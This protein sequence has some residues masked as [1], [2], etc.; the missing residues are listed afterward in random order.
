MGKCSL[1]V[2]AFQD[3]LP[4]LIICSEFRLTFGK[5]NNLLH[6]P[7]SILNML[8]GAECLALGFWRLFWDWWS[9]DHNSFKE[10]LR[11]KCFDD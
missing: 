1:R 6:I 9:F 5:T 10:P 3:L 4:I 7:N 8:L 2:H 11:E